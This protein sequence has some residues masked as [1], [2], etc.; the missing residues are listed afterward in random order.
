MLTAWIFNQYGHTLK[1]DVARIM[2]IWT[3]WGEKQYIFIKPSKK[4]N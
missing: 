2:E 1:I 4:L 3:G